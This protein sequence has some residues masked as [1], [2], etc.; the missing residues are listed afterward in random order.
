[1]WGLHNT[2]QIGGTPDADID[3]PEAWDTATGSADVVVSVIDT[4][5][6]YNHEDLAANMWT[7]PGEIPANEIDDD[8]N[9]YVDDVYG[10]DTCNGDSDP[11]DDNGHPVV[12]G[13]RACGTCS[14]H[15]SQWLR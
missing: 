3:A 15:K 2:G 1:M 12:S 13:G 6:D 11:F 8:S 10:I 9:G 5:V 14:R 4:G 7:N